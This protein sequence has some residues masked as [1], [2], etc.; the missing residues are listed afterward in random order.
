M[1][2]R[3]YLVRDGSALAALIRDGEVS[4]DEVMAC[5]RQMLDRYNADLNAVLECYDEPLAAAGVGAPFHG[6]PFLLKDLVVHAAG[7]RIE[8]GSRLTA[9]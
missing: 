5:A 9:T 3:D 1:E 4:A 8:W 7:E 6:V 2:P